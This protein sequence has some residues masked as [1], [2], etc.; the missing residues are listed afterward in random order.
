[1][2][3]PEAAETDLARMIDFVHSY[4]NTPMGHVIKPSAKITDGVGGAGL[5]GDLQHSGME[6]LELLRRQFV[7]RL[8]KGQVP[9]DPD[10]AEADVHAAQLVDQLPHPVRVLRIRE[11]TL[12]LGH[13]QLRFDLGIDRSVHKSPET[14]GMLMVDPLEIICQILI[15]IQEPD[16]FQADVLLIDRV[17]KVRILADGP[18]RTYEYGAFTQRVFSL[19]LICHLLG[20]RLEHSL[21]IR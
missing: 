19:D 21:I 4:C 1:M 9:V 11:D 17:N 7:L 20:D 6:R 2:P 3:V 12:L 5:R 13:D 8:V 14:Q 16:I 15:H 10:A 18:H